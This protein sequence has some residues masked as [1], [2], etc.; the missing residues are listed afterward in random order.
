[1]SKIAA[2]DHTMRVSHHLFRTPGDGVLRRGVAARRAPGD[3]GRGG[4]GRGAGLVQRFGRLTSE[5]NLKKTD[6]RG[7]DLRGANLEGLDC[8]QICAPRIDGATPSASLYK[9][10]LTDALRACLNIV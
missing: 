10:V 1:M 8:G 6:L 5:L 4:V 7:C 2:T 3:P 9:N